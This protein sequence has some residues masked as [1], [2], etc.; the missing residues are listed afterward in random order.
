MERKLTPTITFFSRNLVGLDRIRKI[1]E[2]RKEAVAWVVGIGG[3]TPGNKSYGDPTE[4]VEVARILKLAGVARIRVYASDIRHEIV[5]RALEDL[6]RGK[7]R[8]SSKHQK[9]YQNYLDGEDPAELE[10]KF[11][12]SAGIGSL[13]EHDISDVRENIT[14]LGPKDAE[15]EKTGSGNLFFQR[16][17][18]ITTGHSNPLAA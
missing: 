6:R 5:K 18:T 7:I 9:L 8:I 12:R 10:A 1:F 4:H 14:I 15:E 3:K 16:N 17:G 2:G 13:T 11:L